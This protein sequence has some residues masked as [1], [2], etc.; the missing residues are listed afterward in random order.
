MSIGESSRLKSREIIVT[1]EALDIQNKINRSKHRR[2]IQLFESKLLTNYFESYVDLDKKSAIVLCFTYG[3]EKKTYYEDLKLTDK[4]IKCLNENV[5]DFIVREYQIPADQIVLY[6][7]DAL[8]KAVE[9][10]KLK[11]WPRSSVIQPEIAYDNVDNSLLNIVITNVEI[12]ALTSLSQKDG[13]TK[14]NVETVFD[15]RDK[16][17]DKIG[18][19]ASYEE[20]KEA[21]NIV[22]I[23]EVIHL[24][25]KWFTLTALKQQPNPPVT[26]IKIIDIINII[27]HKHGSSHHTTVVKNVGMSAD[28]YNVIKMAWSSNIHHGQNAQIDNY[29]NSCL[30]GQTK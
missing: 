20:D 11:K 15:L 23:T 17:L 13:Q 8:K 7:Y 18:R 27:M 9:S 16:T 22:I 30:G 3:P 28:C 25:T 19:S 21:G 29:V 26:I 12:K 6:T 5:I 14:Q 4:T 10:G 2:A 1:P 24:T